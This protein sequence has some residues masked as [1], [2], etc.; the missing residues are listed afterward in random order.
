MKDKLIKKR[1]EF[2]QSLADYLYVMLG[3]YIDNDNMFDA[4]MWY[5]LNLNYWCVERNIYLN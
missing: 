3:I 4:C 5:A 2:L 1:N